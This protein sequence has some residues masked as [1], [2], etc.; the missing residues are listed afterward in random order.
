LRA[1]LSLDDP[2]SWR[3]RTTGGQES[4]QLHA[5][6][7]ANSLILLPDGAG[8]DAGERVSVLLIDPDRLNTDPSPVLNAPHGQLGAL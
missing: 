4:H 6:S 1:Q 2:L 3:V 8:V 5:M 7:E